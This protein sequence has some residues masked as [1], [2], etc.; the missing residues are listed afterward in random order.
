MWQYFGVHGSSQ[1]AFGIG[2][3]HNRLLLLL[4]SSA[5]AESVSDPS[6]CLTS[7]KCLNQVDPASVQPNTVITPGSIDS[8]EEYEILESCLGPHAHKS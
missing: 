5:A 1:F 6:G 7:W 4:E 2:I 8:V 3:R